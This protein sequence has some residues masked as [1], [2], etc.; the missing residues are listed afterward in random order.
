MCIVYL[1]ENKTT[2]TEHMQ[3]LVAS[4]TRRLAAIIAAKGG[5]TQYWPGI[6]KTTPTGSIM[7]KNQIS[8]TRFTTIT[9]QWHLGMLMQQISPI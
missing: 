5:D 7:Q 4:M 1:L 6:H 3:C 9:I 2:T 8:L